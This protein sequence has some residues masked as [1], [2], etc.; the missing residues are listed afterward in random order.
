VHLVK[1]ESRPTL[2][3]LKYFMLQ[4]QHVATKVPVWVLVD[5]VTNLDFTLD[6][7]PFMEF[8]DENT[9]TPFHFIVTGREGIGTWVSKRDLAKWAFD[10][11]LFN[12]DEGL[13]YSKNLLQLINNTSAS[14]AF[15]DF[16]GEGSE[17]HIGDFLEDWFGGNPGLIAECIHHFVNGSSFVAYID[18]L[19]H[20]I[21]YVVMKHGIIN[22]NRSSEVLLNSIKNNDWT[23]IHD[24]G[25]CGRG[26]PRGILLLI[27]IQMISFYVGDSFKEELQLISTLQKPFEQDPGMNVFLVEN[28][29]LLNMKVSGSC[30]GKL[31]YRWDA[32]KCLWYIDKMEICCR[33]VYI[34][35]KTTFRVSVDNSAS[36]RTYGSEYCFWDAILFPIGFPVIKLAIMKSFKE[37]V[38]IYY[39]AIIHSHEPFCMSIEQLSD[40]NKE[41]LADLTDRIVS[42]FR[43][44]VNTVETYYAMYAPNWKSDYFDKLCSDE[45]FG[46][47]FLNKYGIFQYK[48]LHSY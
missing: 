25:L 42:H 26:G 48:Y 38:W 11:P 39:V 21:G 5:D 35:D 30:L 6:E 37:M 34:S 46:C 16:L 47:F 41:H 8:P 10:L 3:N 27:L 28:E 4:M 2:L 40:R 31:L 44:N 23:Y 12:K 9:H 45:T 14:A 29:F 13:L 1:F 18:V 20:R 43:Y 36:V 24:F 15:A 19:K 17:W 32:E 33:Y 7:I 22:V